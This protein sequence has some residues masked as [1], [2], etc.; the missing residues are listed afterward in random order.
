MNNTGKNLS[1]DKSLEVNVVISQK[2]WVAQFLTRKMTGNGM[3]EN[4][5]NW[6]CDMLSTLIRSHSFDQLPACSSWEKVHFCLSR[7][8]GIIFQLGIM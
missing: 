7:C 4:P 3:N 8:S 5:E 1:N 2:K 6:Q